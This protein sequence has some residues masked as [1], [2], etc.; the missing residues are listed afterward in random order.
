M[1]QVD[2]VR[3][4]QQENTRLKEENRLLDEELYRLRQAIRALEDLQA[5][6]N[7]VTPDT[8]ISALLRRVVS[9]AMDAV[10]AMNGSLLLLDE[11]TN[12]LVFVEVQ[13]VDRNLLSGYRMPSDEG[14][15]GWVATTRT[16]RLLPDVYN[17]PHFSRRVDDYLGFHTTSL[18]CV[19]LIDGERTLGV[20]EVLNPRV[21][22]RFDQKDLDIMLLVARLTSM[23]L[24][25]AEA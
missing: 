5:E 20:V 17:D 10:D 22:D 9:S 7:G 1:S 2:I 24:I 8:D 3:A 4:L 13:G 23:L 16:P 6:I 25:R 14:I 19:P 18:L 15:A 12:E 21:N 11:E